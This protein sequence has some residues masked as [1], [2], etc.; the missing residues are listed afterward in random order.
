LDLPANLSGNDRAEVE[1]FAEMLR[2]VGA[3]ERAGATRA[4]AVRAIYPDVYPDDETG[5]DQ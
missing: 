3:A 5:A 4:E 1:R 2:Q